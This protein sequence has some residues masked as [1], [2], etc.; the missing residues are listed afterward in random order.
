MEIPSADPAQP[1]KNNFDSH[2]SNT[3]EQKIANF[4]ELAKQFKNK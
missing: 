2:V 4:L 3:R 1:V